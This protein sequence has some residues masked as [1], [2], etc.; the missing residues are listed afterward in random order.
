MLPNTAEAA[1]RQ[2]DEL[3]T[4]SHAARDLKCSEQTVR[5]LQASGQLPAIKTTSGQRLF[6]RSDLDRVRDARG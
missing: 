3:L 6:R 4:T 1:S 5:R 2:D